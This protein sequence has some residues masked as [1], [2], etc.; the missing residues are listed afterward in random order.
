MQQYPSKYQQK[1]YFHPPLHGGT[2]PARNW[3]TIGPY[4]SEPSDVPVLLLI[5]FHIKTLAPILLEPLKTPREIIGSIFV[6][7]YYRLIPYNT[8]GLLLGDLKIV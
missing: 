7:T 6:Q 8:S 3:S 2:P 5:S 4:F 1:K